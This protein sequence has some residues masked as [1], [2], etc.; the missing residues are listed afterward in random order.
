ME[1]IAWV[2]DSTAYLDEELRRNKDIY[3]IPITI[4][5]DEEEFLDGVTIQ[6][7]EFFKRL[8]TT[9]T[10]PKTSQPSIGSFVDLYN[11]LAENYDRVI[12]IHVASKLSGTYSSALQASEIVSIPVTVIDSKILT[13]PLSALLKEGIIRYQTGDSIEE[14]EGHIKRLA[15]CNETYVLIGSLEQLHRSGRMNTAQYY[16]GSM[17]QIKPI[18]S[19]EDGTLSVKEKVR[20][21]K[22]A[23]ERVL[24]YLKKSLKSNN[25]EEV[26]ILY[27]LHDDKAMEWKKKIREFAEHVKINAYPLGTALGVHAG[28][29]TIGISWINK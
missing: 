12:S 21:E 18:I 1:R 4:F 3:V 5:F 29:E 10:I 27:G 2:T 16:L 11:Q 23:T 14:I 9:S 20:S 8:K 28:E 17:L 26:F 24:D 25:I 7:D 22:K 15:D 13:Y 19:I 6:P